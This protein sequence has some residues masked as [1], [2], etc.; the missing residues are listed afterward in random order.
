MGQD[1]GNQINNMETPA[2]TAMTAAACVLLLAA[3]VAV[4]LP[5]VRFHFWQPDTFWLIE[6]G[7]LILETHSIPT[8]DVYS[9]TSSAQHW[10]VYQ[11][12]TEVIFSSANSL[13]GLSAVAALG[14]TLLAVLF[15]VL[16]FRKMLGQGT[17]ALVAMASIWLTT[18][19]FFPY[20]AALRPQLISF[21]LFWLI[22]A[23]CDSQKRDKPDEGSGKGSGEGFSEV[24]GAESKNKAD[25]K[26]R[27]LW[28]VIAWT[29]G[30]ATL[31][32]NCHISFPIALVVLGANLV[33]AWYLYF[34]KKIDLQKPKLFTAMTGAFLAGTMVTPF[35]LSLWKFVLF[36]RSYSAIPNPELDPLNWF[37][38]PNT[39]T[40]IVLTLLSALYLRKK[41]DLGDGLAL[42]ALLLI[43]NSCGRLI[44]Y[45]YIFGCPLIGRAVTLLLAAPLKKWRIR[46]LS[47][48]VKSIAQSRF[49][50]VAVIFLALVIELREPV[51]LRNTYPVEAAKY[52][53]AHKV[54]G[55]LFSDAQCG[56][57][58]I[59]TT[60]G[61]VPV[62]FDTRLDQYDPDFALRF[63]K[64]YNLGEGWQELFT[65]YNISAALL[66]NTKRLKEILDDQQDWQTVYH[67]PDF[68]LY[69]HK[70][71]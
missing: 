61:T 70:V 26:A 48:T 62:F 33:N 24:L 46:Q 21:L 65:Q 25:S 50:P 31:W 40:V 5:L 10:T 67:D 2:N 36:T 58:L 59:Y 71:K 63:I 3:W 9:F 54:E 22:V 60:H 57:Y 16:I 12:L 4:L 44:I 27:P 45:F 35:G 47:Q 41:I 39:I 66:P 15:C 68:S 18:S 53:A 11:W 64:A 7:R 34:C 42:I 43:G 52:I 23:Q 69:V 37:A 8:H 14:E 38:Q 28:Q 29:F 6:V 55:K 49:Y 20:L 13:G 32:A 30:I 17:N 51:S 1:S 19:A 56:S